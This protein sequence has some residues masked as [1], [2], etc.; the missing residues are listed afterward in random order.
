MFLLSL[1]KNG[2]AL[3]KARPLQE[4]LGLFEIS[5][6]IFM[7]GGRDLLQRPDGLTILITQPGRTF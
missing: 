7:G 3:R 6:F 2:A 5:C 1:T 4:E